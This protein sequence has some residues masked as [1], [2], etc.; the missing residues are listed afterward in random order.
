MKRQGFAALVALGLTAAPAL[1]D[2]YAVDWWT[3][4]CGGAIGT[5]TG[6]EY[7][8]S[9]TIG[10]FDAGTTMAG[11]DY[12]A[13]GGFWTGGMGITSDVADPN[14]GPPAPA[15]AVLVF[16][17]RESAPNPFHDQVTVAFELP[18]RQPVTIAVYDLSGRLRRTIADG[19]LEAGK[20]ERTWDG[21][22]A[23]GRTLASGIYFVVLKTPV[24]QH[25]EKLVKVR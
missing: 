22:D 5:V 23:E 25:R 13:V 20:H 12:Q 2:E 11:G 9:G 24:G 8:L 6:G 3:I 4:D 16:H 10:Q 7:A 15:E 21:R 19:A 18:S 17:A 14:A 1:G